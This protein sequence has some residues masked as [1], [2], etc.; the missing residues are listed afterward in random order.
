MRGAP[1]P[2]GSAAE[3]P[4]LR[5]LGVAARALGA[6]AVAAALLVWTQNRFLPDALRAD[7]AEAALAWTLLLGGCA[8]WLRTRDR[9][10]RRLALLGSVLGAAVAA[11]GVDS[12]L[13]KLRQ[14]ES[15]LLQGMLSSFDVPALS[16]TGS[17]ISALV[18]VSLLLMPLGLGNQIAQFFTLTAA[19]ACA[20]SF[21][22][23]LPG[24]AALQAFGA[25]AGLDAGTGGALLALC[26]GLFAEHQ[27]RLLDWIE[28]DRAR[29]K[30]EIEQKA[31]A[32][33]V[34]LSSQFKA[35]FLIN[36]S[37]E[38][39]TPMNG[40]VGM[41]EALGD[42][43]LDRHQKEYVETANH[44][45][46]MLLSTLQNVLQFWEGQSGSISY[47]PADVDVRQV[48]AGAIA[49]IAPAAQKKQVEMAYL[50][51][52]ECPS[53]VRGDKALIHSVLVQLLSNAVKFSEKGEITVNVTRP[54]DKGAEVQLAFAVTDSG[55]G[56]PLEVQDRL[57][58]AFMQINTSTTK[59]HRGIGLGL[60]SAKR[61]VE[62]MGG[63]IGVRSVPGQGATFW[64]SL[65]LP[66]VQGG[67][68]ARVG[69]EN[70]R[71]L[72]VND[73][74]SLQQLLHFQLIAMGITTEAA[75]GGGEALVRLC[76]AI[77]RGRPFSAVFI[78]DDM[79]AEERSKLLLSIRSYPFL[80]RTRVVMLKSP[81]RQEEDVTAGGIDLVLVKPVRPGELEEKLKQSL[82]PAQKAQ[83][84]PAD[85]RARAR[86]L[87]AE[88][89]KVNQRVALLMLKKL[90]LRA[91]I[92][93]DGAEALRKYQDGRYDL[94]LMDCSMPEMDGYQATGEIR[95][96]E[97]P[98]ARVPIIALTANALKGDRKKC[99]DA[100]M[101]A[102]LTK[103]VNHGE[104]FD[105][106]NHWLKPEALRSKTVINAEA[107]P[108]P[109]SAP[110]RAAAHK[111]APAVPPASVLDHEALNTLREMGGGADDLVVEVVKTFLN[112][113]AMGCLKDIESALSKQSAE[114][115]RK[116]AHKL[117]GSS[118]AV[119]AKRLSETCFAL[120]KA[121][122][123][124]S[125]ESAPEL[126][127]ELVCH[128]EAA[129]QELVKIAGEPG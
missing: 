30:D 4:V 31:A 12:F 56:V 69:L 107:E 6:I 11:F 81:G 118:R 39:R 61:M 58:Q 127:G 37:H 21:M 36:M 17:L 106:L 44:S 27:R 92:A 41:L 97:G 8:L 88:D 7:E 46:Q 80:N 53:L 59:R 22:R 66:V 84:L 26:V 103:P 77:N 43:P 120:E 74:A 89:D 16:L 121:G 14:S 63:S 105:A 111:P 67:Q 40:I 62:I 112:E 47:E 15:T 52:E 90:G 38:F 95:K 86:I 35:D 116:S 20:L 113:E 50:V 79:P 25:L 99:L 126:Y 51:G 5:F 94:I 75:A 49:V 123:Q 45:A 98:G 42:T 18:G 23:F 93:S 19:M 125:I 54:V 70:K 110:A 115:L 129:R 34:R 122:A 9:D 71:A 87:V 13:F 10:A 72:V 57:F 73:R 32:E 60:V 109:D 68:R 2:G 64:F 117:K 48:V 33:L 124:N 3:A 82:S 29:V 108:A 65:N 55:P 1:E 101:D 104:L 85:V 128:F 24:M 100:G 114:D 83:T 102:Y 76:D 119:G 28:L 91:D 78:N 96:L